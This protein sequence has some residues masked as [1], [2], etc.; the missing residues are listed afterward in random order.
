LVA[1]AL[2]LAAGLVSFFSPCVVPLVPG[3][4]AYVTGLGGSLS[5]VQL[6]AQRGLMLAG[7]SLF[8]LGF[9][10]VFVLYGALFGEIGSWL[11]ASAAVI[12]KI[13]GAFVIVLGVGYLG[14]FNWLA[15]EIRLPINPARGIWGAPIVGVVFALGWTPC[16]GPTLAAVQALAFSQTDAGKGAAL[17]LFYSLGL[18]LPFIGAALGY[19]WMLQ[20]LPR[21]RAHQQTITRISGVLLIVIGILL[22]TGFWADVAISLRSWISGFET[23]I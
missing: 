13:L 23:V 8:V 7:V 14:G 16:I 18:G 10:A 11:I 1:A 17:S 21:V 19:Q 22:V 4:L 5:E 2:A 20:V 3:Y 12:E 9:S 6:K 15:R